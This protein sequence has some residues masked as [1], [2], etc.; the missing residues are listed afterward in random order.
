LGSRQA[1]VVRNGARDE[2]SGAVHR[3][4]AALPGFADLPNSSAAL[5]VRIA[6]IRPAPHARMGGAE[7]I[8]VNGI[9]TEIGSGL[10]RV[11][12]NG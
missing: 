6:Q 4:P 2:S 8:R 12:A 11:L 9:A 7:I 10:Q 1:V 5:A 3:V